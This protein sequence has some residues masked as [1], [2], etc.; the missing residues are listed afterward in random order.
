MPGERREAH[1][2]RLLVADVCE[3][4]V[5]DRQRRRRRPAGGG[6]DWW[7]SAAR[8]SVFSATVL[9]PVFGPLITSACSVPE[10]EIDRHGRRRIEQRVPRADQPHLVRDLDR[11]AAPAARERRRVRAPGR[12]RAAASTSGDE[13][14]RA[15]ADRGRRARAGSARPPRARRRRLRL[16]VVQLDDRRTARRT[17]SARSRRCRGRC[18]A[19]CAA[20]LAFT[21]ST[22]RPPRSVT[23]SSCRCSRRPA[24][25]RAARAPRS[26]R[27]RP[28]RSS[29]R[30]LRS[31]GEAVS[32]RSEPSSSIARWIDLLASGAS[33]GSIA[34]RELAQERRGLLG[35]V[36][37]GTRARAP[38]R[39]SSATLPQR[40][41][42]EHASAGRVRRRRRARRASPPSGGSSAVVEQRD[43]LGR[44]RLAA[45]D[46]VRDRPTARARA[47]ARRRERSRS[48]SR[49]APRSPETRVSRAH[50]DSRDECRPLLRRPNSLTCQ[51]Q[52]IKN[53]NWG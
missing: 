52:R 49:A 34:A 21:A 20:A 13:R 2:D 45:S 43:R 3:H 38:R 18:R 16:A 48:R 29:P 30:S 9:P 4:L 44:Q 15:L 27:W 31:C 14:V 24:D 23:K 1:L 32:R 5:E 33:A 25:R 53:W 26:T 19:R 41:G 40:P 39:S 12:S 6:R 8:P 11:R 46:L 50:R 10:V 17:A 42:C 37:S 47:R 36:E 28:V 7:S 22:G 35:I 51:L